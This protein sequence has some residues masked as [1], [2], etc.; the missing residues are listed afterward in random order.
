MDAIY[1]PNKVLDEG[2][3]RDLARQLSRYY[4]ELAGAEGKP[5][6]R[7]SL[8]RML[9]LMT[10]PAG[11]TE[12]YERELAQAA[13]ATAGEG[14]DPHRVRVPLEAL[15]T[16]DL[17]ASGNA[18]NLIGTATAP[19][20]FDVLRPWSVAVEAGITTVPNLVG[21][22]AIPR[23]STASSAGWVAAEG[24]TITT[25]DPVTGLTAMTMKVGAVTVLFSRLWSL[26]ASSAGEL[27]LRQQLLGAVGKLLDQ[28]ILAGSG[29]NGEPLGLLNTPNVGTQSGSSLAHAG[30]IA[31]RQ[32]VLAA[33]GREDNLRWI[34]T[35]AVQGLLAARERSISGGRFL[36]DDGAIL[37]RPASAT[38]YAPP[39]TLVC[40]D[41]SKAVLG[42]WGPPSVT[43]EINPYQNFKSVGLA[44][45]V[46]LAVDAA[47]PAP[48]AF[49]VASSIT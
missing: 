1:T 31:M 42:M 30:I 27:L 21:D 14:F 18:G 10:H 35:P 33:G 36:W 23:V 15:A 38:S 44:A 46:V 19:Q 6:P 8:Q 16:R 13:A 45:R 41:F 7:F 24:N 40:G 37:G 49:C 9:Q 3:R 48:G 5:P 22:F 32:A 17:T 20:P 4:S 26:Q 28:A 39:G 34:G 11:L 12:G 2:T 25:S 43:V 47:F 29:A